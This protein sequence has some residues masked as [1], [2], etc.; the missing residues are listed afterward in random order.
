MAASAT[1]VAGVSMQIPYFYTAPGI[2]R[3]NVAMEIPYSAIH[4]EKAKKGQ[5]HAAVNVL[6]IAYREG[7]VAARFSDTVNLDFPDKK[8]MEAQ[9]AR[10]FH[11][12]SQFEIAPGKYTLKVVFDSGKDS[13]GKLEAPLVI[14]PWD[15]K[16]FAMS[17]MAFAREVRML[18]QSDTGL[19]AQ[20]L[21]DRKPLVASGVQVTPAGSNRLRKAAINVVYL[22]LYDSLLTGPTPPFVAIQILLLDQKTGEQ[23]GELPLGRIDRFILAGNLMVPLAL[24]LPTEELVPGPYRVEVKAIDSAGNEIIRKADV[25]VD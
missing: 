9:A 19:A 2:A 16:R 5:F 25:V 22:E 15:G 13:F 7:E 3:A 6:G 11:Y 18:S 12:E 23:K 10:M 4:F 17:A 24:R 21:D 14:D 1:G 8:E 20:L